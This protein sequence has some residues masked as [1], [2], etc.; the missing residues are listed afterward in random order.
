VHITLTIVVDN[1][2][3]QNS[4]NIPTYPLYIIAQVLSMVGSVASRGKNL[5]ND[6]SFKSKT[7]TFQNIFHSQQFVGDR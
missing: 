1:S 3:A 6:W 7:S 4:D 2:T 5:E